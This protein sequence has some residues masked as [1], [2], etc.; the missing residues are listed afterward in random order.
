MERIEL[1][2]QIRTVQGKQVR[3]LRAQGWIPAVVFGADVPAKSIQLEERT[4]IKALRQAGSTTLIDLFVD[5]EPEPHIVLAHDIQW[6]TLTA[7]LHHVDFYQVRLDRKVKTTPPIE[8]V[9]ESPLV[10]AGR[11]VL[12]Q[13]LG[14]VEV[15]C[16]PSELIHSIPVDVSGLESLND[17]ITIA[18]LRLPPGVAIHADPGDIVVSVVPP[19]AA[20][21][22]DEE[23]A[24]AAAAAAAAAEAALAAEAAEDED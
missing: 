12:V 2:S 4:L 17:S 6:H 16:L 22:T 11:A 19:R 14:H 20:L 9:G 10:K 24:A 8:I 7:K 18:D 3:R 1:R 13:V 23:E 15:E 5:D 21:M